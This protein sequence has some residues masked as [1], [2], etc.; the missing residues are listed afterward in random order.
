MVQP[1]K[2]LVLSPRQHRL[3]PWPGA[4]GKRSIIVT[5]VAQIQSL[6]SEL[7]YATGVSQKGKK[8]KK[9]NQQKDCPDSDL[10]Q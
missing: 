7:A 5:A 10:A 9:K 8:E 3:S 4:V 6:A 1:V 2:D